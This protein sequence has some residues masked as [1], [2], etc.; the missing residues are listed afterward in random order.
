MANTDHKQ[1]KDFPSDHVPAKGVLS[2]SEQLILLQ[3]ELAETTPEELLKELQQYDRIESSLDEQFSESKLP[4]V[5]ITGGI[6]K[7]LEGVYQLLKA[8]ESQGEL[9]IVHQEVGDNI[10]G[11]SADNLIMDDYSAELNEFANRLIPSKSLIENCNYKL[12]QKVCKH[13]KPWYNKSRW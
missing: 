1:L 4:K 2:F 6:P 10:V 9:V 3:E 13:T 11:C 7:S 5:L 12:K 8:A